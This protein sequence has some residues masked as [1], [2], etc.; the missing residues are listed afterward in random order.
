[1]VPETATAKPVRFVPVVLKRAGS[2]E[3]LSLAVE[4]AQEWLAPETVLALKAG[5]PMEMAVLA[6]LAPEASV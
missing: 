1:M 5:E 3:A 4:M 6:P 2:L